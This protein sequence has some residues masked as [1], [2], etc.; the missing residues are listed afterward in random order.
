MN[1]I[2]Y[3]DWTPYFEAICKRIIEFSNDLANR[4]SQLLTMARNTFQPEHAILQYAT[5]DPFSYIYALAQ[6]NTK[7]QRT[8]TFTKAKNAFS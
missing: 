1:N 8:D 7:N 4:E 3:Y 6:R 5:I 2:T